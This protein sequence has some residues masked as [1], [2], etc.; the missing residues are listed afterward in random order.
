MINR[1]LQMIKQAYISLV[2]DDSSAYPKGQAGYNG[3]TTD[4]LRYS[5]YGLNSNPPKDA[6]VLLLG[7]QGQEA[8]KIGL[9]AD[10]LY[11]KKGLKEGEAVLYNTLSK[12]FIILKENG[13]IEIDAK[14]D[15][16]VNVTGN[17]R[18]T[19]IGDIE[20]SAVK[21]KLSVQ[22]LGVFGVT[23]T[24]Q[25]VA[26]IPTN[27]TPDRSYDADSTTVAELA[28]VLGTLIADLKLLGLIG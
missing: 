24:I 25:P 15:L 5:P 9:V 10:F 2:T 14:N 21:T 1:F 17:V 23:P 20:L 26:Y 7:S 28:D 3:K 16:I 11:R 12:S 8:V 6:W 27:V 13:D 19:A 4:F 18:I 22:Q